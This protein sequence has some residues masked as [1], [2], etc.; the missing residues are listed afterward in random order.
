MIYYIAFD[1]L[2]LKPEYRKYT[3]KGFEKKSIQ[4]S[5]CRK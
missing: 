3:F 4:Q 1:F 2:V 5:H